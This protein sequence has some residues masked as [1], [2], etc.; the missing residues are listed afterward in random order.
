MNSGM[1]YFTVTSLSRIILFI[2][3]IHSVVSN[4]V[5]PIPVSEIPPLLPL[6]AVSGIGEC[7]SLYH[8][9]TSSFTIQAENIT[10]TTLKKTNE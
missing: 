3:I 6:S 8:H 5:V 2:F 4:R 9:M 1:L 7:A 10:N